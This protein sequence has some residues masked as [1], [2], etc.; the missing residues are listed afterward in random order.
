MAPSKLAEIER[1][2]NH[3]VL[4]FINTVHNRHA[5]APAEYLA[6]FEDLVDWHELIGLITKAD[7]RELREEARAH[8]RKAAAA[9]RAAIELRELLH[10]IFLAL[11]QGRQPSAGELCDLNAA[12]NRLRPC[13]L[14]AAGERAL[15]WRWDIDTDQPE[16]LLGPLV[17]SAAALLTSDKL[18][19][20]RECPAPHG[21]GWLFLDTSKNG[22]RNWCSMKT[23]GNLAKV[24]RHRGKTATTSQ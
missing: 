23:C 19:R 22:S 15:E 7:G 1:L 14:L 24:R 5:P 13:C 9:H 21:C 16:T 20:I 2:G 8:P 17:E 3:P 11:V 10:A 18:N 12:L 6:T 4:D